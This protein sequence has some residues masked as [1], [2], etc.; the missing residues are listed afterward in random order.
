MEE[1]LTEEPATGPDLLVSIF[2]NP[3]RETLNIVIP[4]GEQ[5]TQVDVI[6]AMGRTVNGFTAPAMEGET[7]VAMD[8]RD[9][10]EGIYFIRTMRQGDQR[11][12][13]FVVGR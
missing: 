2:P 6:D 8:I 9:L 10:N 12:Q 3:A 11:V 7:R 1:G 5:P 4:A 13:R